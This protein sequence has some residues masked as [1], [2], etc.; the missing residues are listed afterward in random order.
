MSR[1]R[2][3]RTSARRRGSVQSR[4]PP[5]CAACA[6]TGVSGCRTSRSATRRVHPIAGLCCR[7]AGERAL[8]SLDRALA[9]PGFRRDGSGSSDPAPPDPD[10]RAEGSSRSG[11]PSD[12]AHPEHGSQR[13]R[14]LD[15]RS[16]VVGLTTACR[17]GLGPPG[18]NRLVREPD[19]QTASLAQAGVILGPVRH[20]V[21]LLGNSVP[22]SGVGFERHG[23]CPTGGRSPPM[24]LVS[25]YQLAYSCNNAARRPP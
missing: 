8:A 11:P 2:H 25:G 6:K 4:H 1:H 10:P 13:Q 7:P 19:R 21:P 20:P 18:G 15:R 23:R 12:A 22:A 17:A 5:R 16:R 3:H 14:R 9:P 24:S